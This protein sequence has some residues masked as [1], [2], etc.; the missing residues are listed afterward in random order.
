MPEDEAA[1][2]RRRK[3]DGCLLPQKKRVLNCT[4]AKVVDAEPD[5][6]T[7]IRETEAALKSLWGSWPTPRGGLYSPHERYDTEPGFENLFDEK[8]SK[9]NPGTDGCSLKDVIT[10]RQAD[11]KTKS[12]EPVMV[13]SKFI[14]LK[15]RETTPP[16]PNTPPPTPASTST[17]V[18]TTPTNNYPDSNELENLLK[19]E[20]ECASIQSQIGRGPPDKVKEEKD[21]PPLNQT[22]TQ[23]HSR[24]EPDFN[25]LA[26]DSS[27]DL[28]IDMSESEKES[29]KSEK[30]RRDEEN[31]KILYHHQT[32]HRSSFGSGS[33][34]RAINGKDSLPRMGMEHLQN[35]G[36]PP[37]GPFPAS[38]T[39]VGYPLPNGVAE[40]VQ[41]HP[42]PLTSLDNNK[43]LMNHT[44]KNEVEHG[45]DKD[46]VSN[47]PES[48]IGSCSDGNDIT[49]KRPLSPNNKQYTILQPAG[50]GSRAA[51][52]IQDVAR[53]GVLSVSA[54]STPEKLS[55][56]SPSSMGRGGQY[57][58]TCCMPDSPLSISWL[59]SKHTK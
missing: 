7:L 3:A 21:R 56:L 41:H 4:K 13:S 12:V 43:C 42:S 20:K 53:D 40:S 54:V 5:D 46:D 57:T 14:K 17:S 29:E 44:I 22:Y 33:A 37:L 1:A 11:A 27:N 16:P 15:S 25:E 31:V 24:Y 48:D 59:P 39:F 45:D 52:A 58:T 19:I 50:A 30:R 47:G 32:L 26:D 36:I 8:K 23:S 9:P 10:L 38:A 18:A 55:P 28:E 49:V 6:E 2:K 51:S 34:F 35:S